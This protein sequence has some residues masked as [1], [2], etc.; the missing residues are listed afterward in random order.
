MLFG[1]DQGGE[2]G[3]IK[4]QVYRIDSFELSGGEPSRIHS[5]GQGF[6]GGLWERHLWIVFSGG[7]DKS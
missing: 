7:E 3:V 1:V 6:P 5:C 4:D 2:G